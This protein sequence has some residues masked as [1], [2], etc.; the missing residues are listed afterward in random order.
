MPEHPVSIAPEDAGTK[1]EDASESSVPNLSPKVVPSTH[2]DTIVSAPRANGVHPEAD[3]ATSLIHKFAS[4]GRL[5]LSVTKNIAHQIG[6]HTKDIERAALSQGIL[7]ER[8]IRNTSQLSLKDQLR[9]LESDVLLVG[10]GGL[11]GHVLDMLARLGVGKITVA[12]GDT[13]E[14]SNLN[15]QLLSSTE[16]LGCSK[17]EAAKDHA[18]AVNPA[19]EVL[20]V[21]EFLDAS[22]LPEHI[23]GKQLV[24]DALGGL[25]TRL[26]LQKAAQQA[27]VPMV[28]AAVAGFSGYVGV[29]LPDE[30]GP[31][32]L[33][34]TGDASTTP[35]E[36]SLGTPAPVVACA[37]AMQCAEAVKILTGK[38]HAK[39]ILF[40]DLNDRT[41]QNV[42]L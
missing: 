20:V 35:V 32:E 3:P 7:P 34:G 15:R 24:I 22:S 9:L 30:A 41:F 25:Q 26:T 2:A 31:A 14:P 17:A 42:T 19:V 18:T 6:C 29:V 10:A 12:D 40:F 37:A 21:N 23:K 4:G 33:L 38:P 8:Y 1:T 36:D 27:G 13:F 16:R 28:T 39:G 5:P 11:G